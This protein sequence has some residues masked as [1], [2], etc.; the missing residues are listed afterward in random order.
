MSRVIV[1]VAVLVL[2]VAVIAFFVVRLPVPDS[3]EETAV[4]RQ[5]ADLLEAV[6]DEMDDADLLSAPELPGA[7]ATTRTPAPS[8]AVRG[9]RVPAPSAKLRAK[10]VAPA[11]R[12]ST[13]VSQKENRPIA[14]SQ[15]RTNPPVADRAVSA[16]LLPA[17]VPP[18]TAQDTVSD[19]YE[20]PDTM[21]WGNDRESIAEALREHAEDY[22]ECYEGWAKMQPDL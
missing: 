10:P 6:L 22:H 13:S 19:A 7:G 12:N 20:M 18:A 8:P 1:V 15:S 9:A 4:E 16:G 21:V 14:D 11:K 3:P 17:P 2:V 5:S